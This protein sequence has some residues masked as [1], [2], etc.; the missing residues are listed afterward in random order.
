VLAE[1]ACGVGADVPGASGDED[2]H[3]PAL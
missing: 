3:A 1:Q 2:R